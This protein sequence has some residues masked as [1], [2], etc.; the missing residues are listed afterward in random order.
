MKTTTP[1]FKKLAF[2]VSALLAIPAGSAMA[3]SVTAID[4]TVTENYNEARVSPQDPT[5]RLDQLTEID[6]PRFDSSLG[7]LRQVINETKIIYQNVGDV[8]VTAYGLPTHNANYNIDMRHRARTAAAHLGEFASYVSLTTLL[9][10]GVQTL[11]PNENRTHNYNYNLP[12]PLTSP[13]KVADA[14]RIP[15]IFDTASL[16]TFTTNHS[17]DDW[18]YQLLYNPGGVGSYTSTMEFSLDVQYQKHVLVK[19]VFDRVGSANISFGAGDDLADSNPSI[20]TSSAANATRASIVDSE[21]LGAGTSVALNM[22]E[23][24]S[25]SGALAAGDGFG[26][27]TS[28]VLSVTGLDGTLHVIEMTYDDSSFDD[29]F[30]ELDNAALNWFDADAGIW[31]NA[32]LGN[33]DAAGLDLNDQA[34]VDAFLDARRKDVSYQTYAFNQGAAG[35]Q[36]GDFGVSWSTDTVWAVIDHNSAFAASNNPVPEP[37]SLAPLA[38]GGF[39][40]MRRRR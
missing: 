11:S 13:I 27:L 34:A 19:Y 28:D 31:R 40:L 15:S 5:F 3:E 7:V 37:T 16:N 36:L 24:G 39:L 4:T 32:V 38:L 22:T 10:T 29:F 35:L 20:V 25:V 8:A 26:N 17:T 6:V 9:Q 12:N 1:G 21:T 18:G 30:D 14:D 2:S 23:Q 33:S